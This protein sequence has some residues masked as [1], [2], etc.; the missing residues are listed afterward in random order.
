MAGGGR[1]A[2]RYRSDFIGDPRRPFS[3]LTEFCAAMSA[4]KAIGGEAIDIG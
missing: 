4:A 3:R 2:S 1:R